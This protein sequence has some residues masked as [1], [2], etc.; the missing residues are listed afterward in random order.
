MTPLPWCTQ[1]PHL[2]LAG[3]NK[4][5]AMRECQQR[6]QFWAR[7]QLHCHV[8]VAIAP[9]SVRLV[10]VQNDTMERQKA[11]SGAIRRVAACAAAAA[12]VFAPGH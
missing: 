2:R 6:Q 12:G 4:W 3:G 7:S 8:A 11:T 10:S 5:C 1:Q 9:V